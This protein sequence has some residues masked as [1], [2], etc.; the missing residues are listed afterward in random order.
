MVDVRDNIHF[1]KVI[2]IH[3]NIFNCFSP[4]GNDDVAT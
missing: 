3:W 2:F 4:F 1:E